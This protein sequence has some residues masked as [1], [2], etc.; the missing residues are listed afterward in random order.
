MSLR[1]RKE[2]KYWF[3][4]GLALPTFL[5]AQHVQPTN[6]PDTLDLREVVISSARWKQTAEHIPAQ[7]AVI[8]PK[9][10]AQFQPQT[11]A[12]LLA[13]SGKVFIQKSQQGGGSPMIR[14]FA[15]NRLIYSVD[16]VRMN[17]AIFRAGNIQ[18]VINLDPFA[19][20]RTEV[21]FG[22]ASV[23]Y[24]SDAI[25]GV[26]SFTTLRPEVGKQAVSGRAQLRYSSVNREQT[27]HVDLHY[28]GK[29][30][31]GITSI[32]RWDFDHLRQGS[33]GPRDYIKARYVEVAPD[34]DVVRTQED[35]LLQVPSCYQQLNVLQKFRYVPKDGWELQYGLH[36]S[37]T[38][39][40]GR[41]DRHNRVRN[42]LPRYAVWDYG[43]QTWQMHNLSLH[44]EA[45]KAYA[46]A[47]TLRVAAQR[48]G[49]SRIDRTLNKPELS[50][51]A[52]RVL[53][54]SLNWDFTKELSAKHSLFYGAEGV[55]NDVAS[56]GTQRNILTG[57]VTDLYSRYPQ[58]TWFSAGIYATEAWEVNP[59]TTVTTGI[60]ASAVGLDADFTSNL[61]FF[62]LPFSSALVRDQGVTGSFGVT[63]RPT[64]DWVIKANVG[65]AFRAPNVDDMGKFFDS[66]PGMLVVPNPSLKSEYAYNA[67]FDVA[68]L[69]G[70]WLK[71]DVAAYATLLRNALVRRP[72]QLGGQD[73][74]MYDGQMSRV[75]AMQNA[76]VARVVGAYMGLEARIS[77]SWSAKT[78]VNV[79]RGVEELDNGELSPSRHAAPTFGL[80]RVTYRKGRFRADAYS[81]FQG[82]RRND[83]LAWEERAK[84]EM[85][86]LDADGKAYCPA[87]YTLNARA[88][89]DLKHG[90]G[91]N[92]G[93]ENLTDQRYRPYSSG[94]SGAGRN[95]VVAVSAKF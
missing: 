85:Y 22:P 48:F 43:P 93:I 33:R 44:R 87:W 79:Q 71:V 63:H 7:V 89:L 35:S 67:D 15:T 12:D 66:S 51:Q 31:G 56:S 29:K 13:I 37:A 36:H 82:P 10:I 11:A 92:V 75:E 39:S 40:Y 16:G 8:T 57:A 47:W 45:N 88:S 5:A 53:A 60:R 32:S 72:F 26:M 46:D 4:A 70:S 23:M 6:S 2:L 59:K 25:G 84:T 19:M 14:G 20:E 49:E 61:P 76:A 17:T 27:G 9:H 54:Y 55:W 50:T 65:T 42:G 21:V 30:W 68:K 90:V 64:A 52:E 86:A 73:S 83:Q 18:N 58:S 80:A 94:I 3:W 81:Q 77:R 41:Y 91:I 74:V 1:K 38:S 34:G 62:P 78:S 28:G 69:F 24:G 95:L